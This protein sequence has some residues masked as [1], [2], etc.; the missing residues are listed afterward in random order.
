M[1]LVPMQPL[2]I[3]EKKALTS[4]DQVADQKHRVNGHVAQVAS[5]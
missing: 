4:K 1:V 3:I 5:V 2:W